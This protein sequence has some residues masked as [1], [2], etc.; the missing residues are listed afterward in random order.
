MVVQANQIKLYAICYYVIQQEQI[1]LLKLLFMEYC[2]SKLTEK[3][4]ILLLMLVHMLT[5]NGIHNDPLY[6]FIKQHIKEH[7]YSITKQLLNV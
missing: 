6:D 3:Q 5:K 7:K 2:K 1:P 4:F